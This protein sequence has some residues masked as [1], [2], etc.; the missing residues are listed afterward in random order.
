MTIVNK[1]AART[2]I[3]NKQARYEGTTYSDGRTWGIITV[4]LTS[5]TKL[6]GSTCHWLI[7]YGDCRGIDGVSDL[8]LAA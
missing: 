1:N 3:A 2:M 6:A 8:G 4:Y 5:N 7:D